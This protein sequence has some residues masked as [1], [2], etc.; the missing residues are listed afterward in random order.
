MLYIKDQIVSVAA[1]GNNLKDKYYVSYYKVERKY[2]LIS[3]KGH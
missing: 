2:S 3:V 1:K